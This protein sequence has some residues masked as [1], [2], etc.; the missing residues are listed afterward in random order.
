MVSDRHEPTANSSRMVADAE[1]NIYA[2]DKCAHVCQFNFLFARRERKKNNEKEKTKE[3]KRKMVMHVGT[4]QYQLVLST[5]WELCDV[6]RWI[7][8]VSSGSIAA[9]SLI[10][11]VE[12]PPLSSCSCGSSS[13][14]SS[15]LEC[16]HASPIRSRCQA[17]IYTEFMNLI[18]TGDMP[19]R[20]C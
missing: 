14:S 4:R 8:C 12:N 19:M 9:Y 6:A 2:V 15:N 3:R 18:L 11:T 20:N 16:H 5:T 17:I 10:D 1:M 7:L 13:S